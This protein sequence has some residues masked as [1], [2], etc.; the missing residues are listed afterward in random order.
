VL[1]RAGAR[2]S[3]RRTPAHG[4]NR[5]RKLLPGIFSAVPGPAAIGDDVT[6]TTALSATQRTHAPQARARTGPPSRR[7]PRRPGSGWARPSAA[8][9]RVPEQ[10]R[11]VPAGPHH[12]FAEQL[13][14]V[15]T[16]RRPAHALLR[17][18]RGGAYDQLVALAP[19][20][21]LRPRGTDRAVPWLV[22]V[23]AQKP[24]DGV[25]EAFAQVATGSRRRALAFRLEAGDDLR[26][27]CA[28]VELDG[29]PPGPPRPAPPG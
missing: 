7:D 5:A 13:L 11:R 19:Y 27:R 17:H 29:L 9:P 26:W 10:R 16:G 12:W 22:A 4:Y 24:C 3:L 15:L 8:A 21:P 18:L 23:G 6:S 25:I 28:A 14:L 20:A 2:S 1:P